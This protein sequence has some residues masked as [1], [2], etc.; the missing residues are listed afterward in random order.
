MSLCTSVHLWEIQV[1]C[2]QFLLTCR[3]G[4]RL[5]IFALYLVD[6]SL[7]LRLSLQSGINEKRTF[8]KCETLVSMFKFSYLFLLAPYHELMCTLILLRKLSPRTVSMTASSRRTRTNFLRGM[9]STYILNNRRR[10]FIFR[11]R[12]AR[13]NRT[14]S[15]SS[16]FLPF[17]K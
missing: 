3:Y 7:P 12:P 16:N 8:V 2:P 15:L 9:Y 10:S 13:E 1:S 17:F 4:F 11:G 5:H 14:R 6:L